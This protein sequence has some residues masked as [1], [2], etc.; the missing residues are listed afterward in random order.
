[1][2]RTAP[3]DLSKQALMTPSLA[4]MDATATGIPTEQSQRR[5][6]PDQKSSGRTEP[7]GSHLH[8]IRHDTFALKAGAWGFRL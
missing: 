8:T 7:T 3:L 4:G 1:M 2:M 5:A 6:A